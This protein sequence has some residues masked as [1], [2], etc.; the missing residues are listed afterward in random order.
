MARLLV[1]TS[2]IAPAEIQLTP[3]CNRF[4]REGENDFLLPHP[5]V[6][7]QHCEV[8]LT[9]DAVLVRD[10]GSRNGTFVEDERVQE[11]QVNDGQTLR[12]GD[13]EM[14]LAEAPVRISIPDL[15]PTGLAKEQ[16]FMPDGTPCCYHHDSVAA[17]LQCIKCLK[18]FCATC[19]RELR[20]AGSVP[21]RFCP[22][23]GGMCE[24]LVATAKEAKRPKWLA[25]IVDAF[26]KPA[27]RK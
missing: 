10:L 25:K 12:L 26:T 20:I 16:L 7:R 8:W 21:R 23:C 19:V 11:A 15:P 14:V 5:S 1:K 2:E 24:P 9:D 27:I 4:G 22:E 13:I 6:S 17:G 3:G 18:A